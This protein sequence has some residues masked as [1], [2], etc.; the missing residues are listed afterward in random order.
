MTKLINKEREWGNQ[1]RNIYEARVNSLVFFMFKLAKML[2]E[3]KDKY[4]Q[5]SQSLKRGKEHINRETKQR[6]FCQGNINIRHFR[7]P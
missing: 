1:T 2:Y 4:P 7:Q 5:I 3:W 6:M